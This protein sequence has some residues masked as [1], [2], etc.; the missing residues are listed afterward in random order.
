M[1]PSNLEGL[2]TPVTPPKS[3]YTPYASLVALADGSSR[4]VGA[5]VATWHWG[6][7]SKEMRDQLRT[8]CPNSSATVYI[9]TYTKDVLGAAKYFRALMIWPS[10]QEETDNTKTVDFTLEFRQ[11]VLQANP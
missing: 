5:P 4:G 9:R 10:T 7:L 6:F 11:L 1:T 2:A 3:T 8:L